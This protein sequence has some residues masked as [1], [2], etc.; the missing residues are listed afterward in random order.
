MNSRQALD[1]DSGQLVHLSPESIL[2][3]QFLLLRLKPEQGA[4]LSVP[5][6]LDS[7]SGSDFA[8]LSVACRYVAIRNCTPKIID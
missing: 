7:V 5:V 4:T 8:S 3:S 1:G 2:W 6:L